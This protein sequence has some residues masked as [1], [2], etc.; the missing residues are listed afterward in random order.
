MLI[1][2]VPI[3]IYYNGKIL[4]IIKTILTG[5][6]GPG[7]Y[8]TVVMVQ[9]ILLYPFVYRLIKNVKHAVLYI[10][11]FNLLFEIITVFLPI[12]M[13]AY[14]LCSFRYLGFIAIGALYAQNK[15]YL[16]HLPFWIICGVFFVYVLNYSNI[17]TVL[18]AHDW[19]TTALPAVFLAFSYFFIL[20]GMSF[21]PNKYI[22]LLSKATF[23]IY[24]F[25]MCWY[26]F[27]FP[28]LEVHINIGLLYIP[29]NIIVCFIGGYLFYRFEKYIFNIKKQI[30]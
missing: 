27:V 2:L 1:Q 26:G 29:I 19:R 21:K 30:R 28:I 3:Y 5:G 18:F 10:S 24:L 17:D 8:Y 16:P 23:H 6:Y 4:T 12:P 22:T 13:A 9:I 7:S 11:M 25:Q 20:K 14:R 15:K